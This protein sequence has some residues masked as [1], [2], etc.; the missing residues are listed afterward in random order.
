MDSPVSI[1]SST[2]EIPS[3]TVPSV[4]IFSPGRTTKMSQTTS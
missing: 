4:A 2:E 3:S 1:D